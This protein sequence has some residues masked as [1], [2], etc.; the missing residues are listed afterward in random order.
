MNRRRFSL[1]WLITAAWLC[2]AG[3]AA[4]AQTDD[5]FIK[6][7]LTAIGGPKRKSKPK[8]KP[9]P[10]PDGTATGGDADEPAAA[11]QARGGGAARAGG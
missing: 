2:S 4:F 3:D 1:F 11:E 5:D 6:K 8:P 9:E 10:K 7:D